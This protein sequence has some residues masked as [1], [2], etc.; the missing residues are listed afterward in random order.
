MELAIDE[1]QRRHPNLDRMMCETLFTLHEH[2]KLDKY[3]L[4]E[5]LPQRLGRSLDLS[6]QLRD[7]NVVFSVK[8][9]SS[10]HVN[11]EEVRALLPPR[12]ERS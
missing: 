9:E 4:D 2:G 1:L 12:A 6:L 10:E 7:F 8:V 3:A 5:K 11:I